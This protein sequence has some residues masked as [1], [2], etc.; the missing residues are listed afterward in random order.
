MAYATH[1]EAY[2]IIMRA[3]DVV[4]DTVLLDKNVSVCVACVRKVC[5][6]R[7]YCKS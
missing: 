6:A 5:V 4:D 1:L 7:R 2:V 3:L